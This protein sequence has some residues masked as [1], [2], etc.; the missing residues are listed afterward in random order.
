MNRKDPCAGE[1]TIGC[2]VTSCRYNGEGAHCA[3][4]RIEVRPCRSGESSGRPD[5]E[6]FCGSYSQK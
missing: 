6:S 2:S 3:L 4:H 5:D 1:Q